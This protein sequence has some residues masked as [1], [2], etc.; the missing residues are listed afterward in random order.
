VRSGD[1]HDRW[2]AG[3]RGSEGNGPLEAVVVVRGECNSMTGR[4]LVEGHKEGRL[5]RMGRTMET[6]IYGW[7]AAGVA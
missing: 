7:P 4:G 6:F 3:W 5:V 2:R 1:T